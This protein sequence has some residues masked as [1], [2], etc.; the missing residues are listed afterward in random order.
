MKRLS[1]K[2]AMKRNNLTQGLD[3]FGRAHMIVTDETTLFGEQK[4]EYKEVIQAPD[5]WMYRI[6]YTDK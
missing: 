2:I 4:F 5:S 3:Q 6:A 1:S